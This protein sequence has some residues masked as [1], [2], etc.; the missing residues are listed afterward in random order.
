[1]K[2]LMKYKPLLIKPN[3]DELNAICDSK[4][5]SLD[6]IIDKA[7]ELHLLGIPNVIVSLSER[8]SIMVCDKGVYKADILDEVVVGTTGSGDS[9]IAGFIFNIQRGFDEVSAYR[10]AACSGLA[11]TYSQGLATR[12]QIE[13]YFD[14]YDVTK[15]V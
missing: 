15:L 1:M 5:D 8:G 12:D 14:S 4:V 11:T 2:K 7:K 10:Y 9:M 6:D 3:L 13:K